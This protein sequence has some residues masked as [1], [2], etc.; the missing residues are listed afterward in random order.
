MDILTSI[1]VIILERYMSYQMST[2]NSFLNTLD[3]HKDL[4]LGILTSIKIN[5]LFTVQIIVYLKR[6]IVI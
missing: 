2:F 6:V 5:L 1:K 4:T 3:L